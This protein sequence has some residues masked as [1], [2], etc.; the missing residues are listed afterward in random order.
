MYLELI[1]CR[2]TEIDHE[3]RIQEL[4]NDLQSIES[5]SES[6]RMQLYRHTSLSSDFTL[7]ISHQHN[8]ISER[9]SDIGMKLVSSLEEWTFVN[10][11]V[12]IEEG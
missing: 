4:I 8:T 5:Q 9:G 1:H 11:S 3:K 7:F 10:H 6:C 12:W 2:A